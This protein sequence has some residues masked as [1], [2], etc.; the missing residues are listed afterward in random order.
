MNGKLLGELIKN[1]YAFSPQVAAAAALKD[2]KN[3][4][5]HNY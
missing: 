4:L 3:I 2:L 5:R 1:L